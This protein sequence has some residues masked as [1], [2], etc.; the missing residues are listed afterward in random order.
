MKP[1]LK[2]TPV[3]GV[4]PEFVSRE[5]AKKHLKVTFE[6]EDELIDA[7]IL[8]SIQVAEDYTGLMINQKNVILGLASFPWV[9]EL[10]YFPVVHKAISVEYSDAANQPVAVA[11]KY[12]F[13]DGEPKPYIELNEPDFVAPEVYQRSDA[14][15]F[16]FVGGMIKETLP[17]PIYQALFLIIGDMYQYR[18]DRKDVVNKASLALMRPYKIWG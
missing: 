11:D 10:D 12:N 2:L 4:Q 16:S 17:L 7:I 14:V 8:S 1:N 5:A 9:L 3:S 13:F 6:Y 15:R 18:T